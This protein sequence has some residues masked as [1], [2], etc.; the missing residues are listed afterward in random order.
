MEISKVSNVINHQYVLNDPLHQLFD[1]VD[2]VAVQ[3]YDENRRVI[4]WNKGSE[5]LYQILY[6]GRNP[7]P[8]PCV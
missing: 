3:G 2:A 6:G 1:A 8:L 7:Q 4:Y 5:L